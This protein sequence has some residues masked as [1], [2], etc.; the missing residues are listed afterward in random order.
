M[1]KSEK[2]QL[3]KVLVYIQ[4]LNLLFEEFKLSQLNSGVSECQIETIHFHA[5]KDSFL[6]ARI[7]IDEMLGGSQPNIF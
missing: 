7:L 3:A 1:S 2:K 6:R 4:N 5:M